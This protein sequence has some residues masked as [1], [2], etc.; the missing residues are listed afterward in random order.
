MDAIVGKEVLL[1]QIEK[2]SFTLVCRIYRAGWLQIHSLYK[3]ALDWLQRIPLYLTLNKDFP[4]GVA[5]KFN[6]TIDGAKIH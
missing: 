5:G 1:S 6:L 3:T 2:T 4:V